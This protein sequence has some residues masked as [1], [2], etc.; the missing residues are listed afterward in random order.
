MEGGSWRLE[1][2]PR[3]PTVGG[4]VPTRSNW[5]RPVIGR[6]RGIFWAHARRP[7]PVRAL[8]RV[9]GRALMLMVTLVQHNPACNLYA[10]GCIY[11]NLTAW[12]I[13]VCGSVP[14]LGLSP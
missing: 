14:D 9:W 12:Q 5:G 10:V 4:G 8:V 1:L 7:V 2:Q 3:I 13:Y 6:G 11:G